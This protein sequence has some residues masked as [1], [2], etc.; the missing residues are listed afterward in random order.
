MDRYGI[1]EAARAIQQFVDDLSNWYVRRSRR[2]FW[3]SEND[4][5]K[6]AAYQTLYECLVTVTKLLALFA[7]F[8]SEEIYQNLAR[9]VYPDAEESVHLCSFPVFDGAVIDQK[10]MH[11]TRLVM[12]VTSLG[13]AARE[14]A[15]IKVRQPLAMVVV[16][17]RNQEERVAL[18]KL[19]QQVL[20]ELNV[21]K[22]NLVEEETNLVTYKVN[23]RAGLLGPK[24]GSM[25]PE[26]QS[27]IAQADQ[28]ELAREIRA[29][30][31]VTVGKYT[32][33]PDELE[34]SIQGCEG[35]AVAVEGDYVVVVDT[36]LTPELKQEGLA[37]ELVHRIQTMRKRA[38]FRIEERIVTCYEGS[39]LLVE[40]M[41]RYADYIQQETLSEQLISGTEQLDVSY[42]EDIT[43]D[44]Q[45]ITIGLCRKSL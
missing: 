32:L 1:T 22:L 5:D 29:H 39:P 3:K 2:R 37:R 33:L 26:I 20:D 10:L 15:A 13:R 40:V 35:Y 6:L 14:R 36:V 30:Q 34:V 7:P 24:Y 44:H 31:A 27:L 8:I 19:E 25:L 4:A 38:D 21:K 41:E 23:T 28:R 16:K 12:R 18:E 43:I 9:S 17:V 11:S 42:R 45:Q